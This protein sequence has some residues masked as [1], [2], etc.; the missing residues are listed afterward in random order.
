[1]RTKLSNNLD[2][3]DLAVL[4]AV[5]LLAGGIAL[6]ILRGDRVGLTVR[7][8]APQGVA[9][10]RPTIQITFDQTLRPDSVQGRVSLEPEVPGQISVNDRIV[11]FRPDQALVAGQNYTVTLQAGV[12]ATNGR[13]LFT[14]E[15]W[16]FQVRT[17]RI[18]YLA[19]VD[20]IQNLYLVDPERPGE[21]QALTTSEDGVLSFDVSPDGNRIAYAQMLGRQQVNLYVYDMRTGESS[22]LVDCP[23]AHCNNP[24][25]R[26]DGSMIAYER[27]EADPDSIVGGTSLPRI[28][29]LDLTVNQIRPLYSDGQRLGYR[30]RWS[31]DGGRLALYD[32]SV[33]GIAVHDFATGAD[34]V[35]RT[36]QGEVGPWSPDGRWLYFPKIVEPETRRYVSHLVLVD[37]SGAQPVQSDLVP[38]SEMSSDVEAAWR[39]EGQ[40]LFVVRRPPGSQIVQ[41]AQIVSID[42]ESRTAAALIDDPAYSNGQMS[43]SPSGQVIAFQRFPLGKRGARSEIWVYDARTERL[44]QAA[45]EGN[46]PRWIP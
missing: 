2:R 4:L 27:T 39:G 46:F 5:L 26:P 35:I 18:V 7:R 16:T 1:M 19:P 42:L 36:P 28:W 11:Q 21:V 45:P 20:I 34:M 43:V 6:V 25:W 38:E 33:G 30:A 24:A 44:F 22:L 37:V 31:P 10:S 15:R 9:S 17:P 3:F 23:K 14:D 32:E 8:V 12:E 41:G 13:Q 40:A 29:L